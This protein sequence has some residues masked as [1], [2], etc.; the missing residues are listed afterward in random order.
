MGLGRA[1]RAPEEGAREDPVTGALLAALLAAAP[2]PAQEPAAAPP[3]VLS[4]IDVLA[5]RGFEDL[6]GKRVGLITNQTGRDRTG[7]TTFQ[8]L[9]NASNVTL[10]ALFSPEHGFTGVAVSS[11]TPVNP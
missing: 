2:A 9:A 10:S 1:L 7:R 4:G 5:E 6:K 3:P 8:I 11:A